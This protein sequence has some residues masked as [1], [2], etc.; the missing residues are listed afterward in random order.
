MLGGLPVTTGDSVSVNPQGT[1]YM[2]L[3]SGSGSKYYQ[4]NSTFTVGGVTVYPAYCK[5]YW[6]QDEA[7]FSRVRIHADTFSIVT[8]A[9]SAGNQVAPIDSYAIIKNG[10]AGARPTA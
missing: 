8:Y 3:N 9:I 10:V 2:T 5:V 1:L 6:Q 7:T 4:L